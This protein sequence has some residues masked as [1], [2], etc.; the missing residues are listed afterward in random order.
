M[1][2]GHILV[3]AMFISF[4]ALLFTGFPVAWALAG[5]GIIFCSIGY[6]SDIYIWTLLL[7]SITTPWDCW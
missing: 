7:A 4:V 6:F 2:I 1:D 5:V 3:I